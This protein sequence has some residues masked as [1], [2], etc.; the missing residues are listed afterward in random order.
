MH[1]E[2]D[3]GVLASKL[4]KRVVR[5]RKAL[6]NQSSSYDVKKGVYVGHVVIEAANAWSLFARCA[7]VSSALGAR[8]ASGNRVTSSHGSWS[9]EVEIIVDATL[10]AKPWLGNSG[11]PSSIP[12]RDEPAWHDANLLQTIWTGMHLSNAVLISQALSLN[13]TF[14]ID[15]PPTRNYFAHKNKDTAA[16][17]VNIARR[18]G[19][20][21]IIPFTG[22]RRAVADL[23][24]SAPAGR[25]QSVI[26]DWLD[27]L[28]TTAELMAM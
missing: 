7:F 15:L 2:R 28:E 1:V 6:G 9:S 19:I 18:Y 27:E 23:V 25:P 11:R 5:L 14:H 10:I 17:V 21:P 4:K 12:R 26:E 3:L 22:R 8:T 20:S 24:M 13:A 16:T